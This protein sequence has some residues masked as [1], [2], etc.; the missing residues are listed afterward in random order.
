MNRIYIYWTLARKR[1][2]EMADAGIP[3]ADAARTV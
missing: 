3:A 1:M 2:N